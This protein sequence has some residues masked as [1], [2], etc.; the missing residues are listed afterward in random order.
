MSRRHPFFRPAARRHRRWPPSPSPAARSGGGPS[1]ESLGRRRRGLGHPRQAHDRD[2]RARLLPV[3]HRRRARERRGLRGRR[4]LRRRRAAR[5]R[6]RRRRVG[7]HDLR[8]G[9]RARARR[10]S[11]STCSSSR[12][13]TSARSRS[14]SARRTTRPRRSSSRRALARRRRRPRSPTSRTCSIGAQTGTTSFTTIEEVIQP[15]QGAQ[16]FNTNDDAKLALENGQVDAIVVDLP[17]AFYITGVELTDGVLVGQLPT[18][19]GATGDEFGLVLA[20]DSPAHRR[21]HRGR[22]RPARGRHARRARRP[23]GS[24]ARARRPCCSDRRSVSL[25]G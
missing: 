2:R 15:T 8:R 23:S 9:H 4:R 13:P 16:A 7:A 19:E 20:K 21:G 18:P 25:T 3:G 24:A 12:S 5:L 17:T 11:T 14:T 22:R 10:T 1:G 6:R